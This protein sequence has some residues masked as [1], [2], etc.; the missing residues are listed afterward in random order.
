MKAAII[1]RSKN[2]ERF[3]G[4]VLQRV[5]AQEFAEPYEVVVLDSGSQDHTCDI[6]RRFPVHLETIPPEQFTFGSALNRGAR[7]MRG[8]YVVFLSAHCLPCDH[9]WLCELLTPLDLNPLVAATYGRQEPLQGVNRFEAMELER[10][11]ALREAK[12]VRAHFSNANSAVRRQILQDYPFDETILGGEDFLWSRLLPRPYTIQY[13]HTA[14]VF[15]SHP[16]TFRYWRQRSYIE[17]LFVSYL[18]RVYGIPYLAEESEEQKSTLKWHVLK[19][20]GG[21]AHG[22]V[23]QRAFAALC[24]Y[25]FYELNRIYFYKKGKKTGARLYPRMTSPALPLLKQEGKAPAS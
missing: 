4:S 13:V 17:G 3:I 5:L 9:R 6:V 8:E 14:R 25:P 1:I 19:K 23:R 20:M 10:A 16:P 11:F 24:L 15:H 12:L 2:E 22:L 21:V 18:E 7:I